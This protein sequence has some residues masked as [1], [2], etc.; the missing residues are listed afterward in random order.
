MNLV[1]NARDAMPEGGDIRIETAMHHLTEDLRRDRAL[2]PRGDYVL[3]RVIDEGHGIPEEQRAKIFEPFFTTK[4]VGEG[5]GLGLSMAY[6]IV[7]QT[8]GFIFVDSAVEIEGHLFH[9]VFP[10]R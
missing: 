8:G 10:G 9:P 1:V 4:K 5:T 3:V 2:V 6:G 7:K